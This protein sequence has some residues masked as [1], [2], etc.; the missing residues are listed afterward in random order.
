MQYC[1]YLDNGRGGAEWWYET[2]EAARRQAIAAAR[3]FNEDI[4]ILDAALEPLE[5]VTAA[6]VTAD[7]LAE[8]QADI[9]YH[10]A[11]IARGIDLASSRY[12]LRRLENVRAGLLERLE[13][14]AD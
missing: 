11:M 2:L 6:S 1:V 10:E 7:M 5:T 8:N 3:A 12:A 4:R 9:D 13:G 14:N